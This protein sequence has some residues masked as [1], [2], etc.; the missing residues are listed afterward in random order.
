MGRRT[1]LD[2]PP[3]FVGPREAS[4]ISGLAT[5]VIYRLALLGAIAYDVTLDNRP[6]L[7]VTR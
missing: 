7:C 5:V 4:R 3:E 6:A 1:V 2:T